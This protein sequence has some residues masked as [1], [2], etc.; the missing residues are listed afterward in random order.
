MTR[1]D[2]VTEPPNQEPS[3][4]EPP[5]LVHPAPDRPGI[6]RPAY[7][8]G[9]VSIVVAGAS[10]L[11]GVT[12]NGYGYHRDELYFR[13]LSSHPAWSYVDQPPMTPMLVRASTGIFGDSLWALRLPAILSLL[14]TIYV[15]AA[16]A[17]EFGGGRFAQTLAAV[18]VVAPFPLIAGHVLLT[19]SPDMVFWTLAILFFLRALLRDEPR[20]WLWTG[21]VVGVSLFNKQ[22]IVL[23]LLGLLA[24]LLISGPRRV[25]K[26]WQL[27]IGVG[28]AVVIALPTLIWQATNHWPELTMA[29]AIS[30]DKGGDDRVMY[31]PFQIILL[32]PM[33]YVWMHG[34][35]GMFRQAEWRPVRCLA[36]A[37]PVVSV[38][39]LASG[40]QIYY[41]F[42]LLALYLAA[43]AVLVERAVEVH[44]RRWPHWVAVKLT[45]VGG[46]IVAL[47]IIPAAHLQPTGVGAI[48]QT[49]RDQVGWPAYVGEVG[50]AY[51][52]LPVAERG[53]VALVAGN[54][55]E[56]GALDKYGHVYGL[57]KVYSG[58]NQLYF[59][60]PPPESATS[61]LFVGHDSDAPQLP[62]FASCSQVGTLDNK[63]G[64][65]NEEQ[66]RLI[67]LCVGR[68][69]PWAQ[70]WPQYQHY[71]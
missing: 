20:W 8:W 18:G 16:I 68:T 57:P 3:N 40:G 31:V 15:V 45:I 7:H 9:P 54:Y 23:L 70:L 47:P 43:G 63:V 14:I 34:L 61:M 44:G 10:V 21:L 24:G 35:A 67:M 1:V 52:A 56:T 2:L 37:Y 30:R 27:W 22:L 50:S 60:G 49:T 33:V 28:I 41:T 65:D 4:Q 51:Q 32:G 53:S 46:S 5:D 42:G 59:Y 71:S 29:G 38:I 58:Q 26:Q 13:L 19:A 25:L 11:L 17:R 62:G 66:G 6:D 69:M 55:G 39:V 48:N 64:L 36:W 12:A